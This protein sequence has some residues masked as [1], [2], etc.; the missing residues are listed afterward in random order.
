MVNKKPGLTATF[1]IILSVMLL[2]VNLLLGGILVNNSKKSMITLI[3]NR[4]LDISNTAADMLDGDALRSLKK[5]DKDT[6]AYRQVND[7]LAY[8]QN[9]IDLK[10]IYCVTAKSE[11]EFVFSVDPTIEDPGIFGEPVVYT[12]ALYRAS[13]GVPSVDEEPYS[14]D[15]GRFYS[16]YSPVF[17]SAGNVAGIVA[18]DFDAEW[19]DWQFKK[20]TI[21]ILINSIASVIIGI[22]LVF[23]ATGGLR[24]RMKTISE[25]IADATRD[26]EELSL[27]VDLETTMADS[28]NYEPTDVQELAVR[29]RKVRDGLAKY[30]GNINTQ[31]N[32]MINALSAEY[33]G[34]YYIDLDNDDGICYRTHSKID[35]GIGRGEHFPYIKTLTKYAEDYVSEDYREDFLKFI[36]PETIRE[37]L[38][39]EPVCTFRYM[40]DQE[41]H[42]SYEMIRM[43]GIRHHDSEP[44]HEIRDISMGFAD[45]DA[46]TRHTL[47]QSQVLSD[48]LL[49]AESASKAKTAFLS[50][51]SHEIRTPMNAI[52]GLNRIALDDP[53]TPE[54]TKEYLKKIGTSAD[55]LLMLINDILDMSRIEAGRMVLKKEVFSL[56]ALLGEI[57]V[58]IGGQCK[59]KGLNWKYDLRN[60]AGECFIGDN[61][62]LKQVLINILGNSVKFTHTGGNVDLDVECISHFKNSSVFRF[63]IKDTGVGMDSEFLPKLFDAFSQESSSVT[64]KYG[65]TGLGMSITKSIVE[66]MNGDIKVESQKN[67]GST[68]TVTVTLEDSDTVP[69]DTVPDVP[70]ESD[71]EILKGKR[72]LLAEDM[73]INAEIIK[74]LLDEKEITVEHAGNGQ[75]VVDM[76]CSSTENYY[77]AILMDMRMP[78]MDGLEATRMIRKQD[79]KDAHTIPIIALTANAFEED[80]QRSLQSGLNSHLSKPVEPDVLYSTLVKELKKKNV[81]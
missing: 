44:N 2:A 79:R 66:M 46:E 9:N 32:N 70:E 43:A 6:P 73:E 55:H 5:E 1:A 56:P 26:V 69:A 72:I 54:V 25:D 33:R 80:V 59:E 76:F 48:A 17:D 4:M 47:T 13:K 52:I 49:S 31:A 60:T 40:I 12:D 38:K 7:T 65:S 63:V 81:L 21:S 51:M 61:M 45:V 37:N 35:N 15:W 42:Q 57:D 71:Y 10:Y 30:T 28:G 77:D 58:I 16:S 14:D 75:I 41:G 34:V 62:K 11:K 23:I 3:Q 68:F 20:Q 78:E 24:R 19:Y 39:D 18:V 22:L 64:T 67:V 53:N 29:I 36:A 8:F 50:N 27:K 74:M